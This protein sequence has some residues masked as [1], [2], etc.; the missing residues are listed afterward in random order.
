M[1]K[2]NG[3]CLMQVDKY[4]MV[5]TGVIDLFMSMGKPASYA[6]KLGDLAKALAGALNVEIFDDR[7]DTPATWLPKVNTQLAGEVKNTG[8]GEYLALWQ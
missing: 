8:Q 3:N 4:E 1:E 2:I 5:R 6:R 7:T